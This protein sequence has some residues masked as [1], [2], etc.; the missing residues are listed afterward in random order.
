[1]HRHFLTRA[2]IAASLL[3]PGLAHAQDKKTLTVYTYESFVSEWGPGPKVK[4][5]FEQRRKTLPNALSAGFPDIPKADLTAIIESCGHRAD[6]RGERLDIAEF[7]ALADK[8]YQYR[9]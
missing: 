7:V 6:I 3:L 8:I 2:L 4:A 9:Q 5:A 1:M